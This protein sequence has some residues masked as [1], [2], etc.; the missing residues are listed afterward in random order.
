MYSHYRMSQKGGASG[1]CP[2]GTTRNKRGKGGEK[3]ARAL[4]MQMCSDK[5]YWLFKRA[6]AKHPAGQEALAPPFWDTRYNHR[7]RLTS[8]KWKDNTAGKSDQTPSPVLRARARDRKGKGRCNN[9]RR[10]YTLTVEKCE[11]NTTFQVLSSTKQALLR[12]MVLEIRV[13]TRCLA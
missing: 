1:P 2:A 3:G 13:T 10:G 11:E 6:R 12:E 7:K 4:S 5:F 9:C 8:T